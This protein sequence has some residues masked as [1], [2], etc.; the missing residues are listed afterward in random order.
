MSRR[1][2]SGLL[3]SAALISALTV[4]SRTTGFVRQLVF[5]GSVGASCVGDT[6]NAANLL[7]TV[8]F[9][10]VAGGAL[11]AALVP[12]LAPLLPMRPAD[13]ARLASAVLTW[14][15]LLL[16]PVVLVL[17]LAAAPLATLLV[18]QDCP[19]QR[20]LATAMIVVF[21]PQVVLYGIGAVLTGLLQAAGRFG[22][23][24][25]APVASSVVVMAGYLGYAAVVGDDAATVTGDGL[26]ATAFTAL[27]WG[28]TAGVA[29]MTL[30]LLVPVRRAGF[31]ITPT[32]ALPGGTRGQ[33]VRLAG[34]GVLAV[35]AQQAF[36]LAVVVLA[37]HRG[38]TGTLVAFGYTQALTVLPHAV[39]VAPLVT[40]LFPRLARAA[41]L[42]DA[43]A[44]PGD[45]FAALAARSVRTVLLAATAGAALLAATAPAVAAL[46]RGLDRGDVGPIQTALLVAAPG[47]VGFGL[48]VVVGRALYAL[49]RAGAA[50][51]ATSVGWLA[52][53]L[54]AVVAVLLAPAEQTLVAL[55]A[56]STAGM[57]VGAVLALLLLR[58]RA[59]RSALTGLATTAAAAVPAGLLIA[60]GGAWLAVRLLGGEPALVRS[61]V[62][63]VVVAALAALILAAALVGPAADLTMAD[64][65]IPEAIPDGAVLLVLG[66]SGG[67][68]GRHVLALGRGLCERGQDVVVVAPSVTIAAVDFRGAGLRVAPLEVGERPN[69]VRD[70]AT[71][72][73]LRRMAGRA[74]LVHAHGLRAGALSVLACRWTGRPHRRRRGAPVV[75]TMHNAR[76]GEGGLRGRLHA[77]LEAL[78]ARGAAS[79]LVVSEDLGERMK[80]LGARH[81]DLALVPAP[82][83]AGS[84][85]HGTD[86]A[87]VRDAVRARLGVPDGVALLVCVARLAPQKGLPVLLDAVAHLPEGTRP[88]QVVLAGEGPMHG[89]LSADIAARDLPVRLL[90]RR[91]DVPDL[92]AA[93][94]LVVVPSLWEGQPLVVQEALQAGAAI[95][96]TD[97]GGTAA[98]AGDAARLVPAADP[99][100]LAEVLGELL[101][102][103]AAVA[104]LRRRALARAA[105]LPTDSHAA[106]QVMALYDHLAPD[107]LEPRGAA[108]A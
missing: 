15:V 22:W 47:L 82:S 68:I 95:V 63:A 64:G 61:L 12:L 54:A 49:G 33:V 62:V 73:R 83:R 78:V 41:A 26:P 34:S 50:A 91:D 80:G 19:G 85:T 108:H 104:E 101:A 13:A 27:A 21:A 56:G 20:E 81:V 31:R 105:E 25:F 43:G 37:N 75:V 2:V 100:A 102:D 48:L 70:L 40:A 53:I 59:G 67:G 6:Y 35:L 29:A 55:S 46:F 3:A 77:V 106:D 92:L 45:D 88:V 24:A 89:D 72:R 28:T 52:A 94:D 79:V 42:D 86:G 98:V 14:A 96:A 51:L 74:R 1:V 93:A 32:L 99:S 90:G 11:A 58:D 76:L 8:L 44:G 5:S 103:P 36:L 107:S 38:P 97:A 30:P 9:E 60:V 39:L 23:P 57:A 4:L 87:V 69:P 66:P 71:L 7:P 10:M 16:A 65:A 17:V 18:G 84:A